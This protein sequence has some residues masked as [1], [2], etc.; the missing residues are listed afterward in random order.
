MTS[1]AIQVSVTHVAVAILIGSSIEAMLPT[2]DE[3]APL[4][5]QI[6]EVV[7]QVG[8]NGAALA[9]LPSFLS[10]NDPTFGILFSHALAISQPDLD[11]R[12]RMLSETVK[13]QVAQVSLQM[14][15][16]LADLSAP[17]R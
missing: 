7:V 17:N 11:R 14:A 13:R 15:P 6:F 9:A 1:R 3:S 4:A 10:Q 16:R 12:M 8:L 2:Y 5:T